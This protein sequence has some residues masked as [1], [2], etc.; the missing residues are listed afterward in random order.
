MCSPDL[1][2]LALPIT[3]AEAVTGGKVDVPTPQGEVT[4]TVPAGSQSGRKLR[5]KGLGIGGGNL[6]VH[7]QVVVPTGDAEALRDLARQLS[8]HYAEDVRGNVRL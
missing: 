6:Y 1:L 3:V 8:D 4:L 5:L 7:L 2:H